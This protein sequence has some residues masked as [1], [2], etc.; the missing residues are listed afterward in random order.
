MTMKIG[1]KGLKLIKSYE[2]YRA[3]AYL[4]TGKVPTIGYGTTRGVKMGQVT[5]EV[6]ATAFLVRDVQEAERT[7]NRKVTVKLT[8]DQFDALV[9][10]VYNI[11]AKQFNSS[12]LLKLL[13]QGHY[14]Q[15]D[16]Q[17]V[18]WNKDNGRVVDG[19]TRRRV[20]EGVLFTS[21]RVQL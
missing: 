14:D 5:N 3:H 16:D 4:D 15:V 21:G 19:L 7:V 12:T 9:C 20:A 6:E 10:F 13:N 2:G 8:Q 18:R 17:L 1:E 11:G